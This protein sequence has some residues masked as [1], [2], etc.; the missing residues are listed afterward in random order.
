MVSL[1]SANKRYVFDPYNDREMFCGYFLCADMETICRYENQK[2]PQQQ[3]IKFTND[4]RESHMY[5]VYI[6]YSIVFIVFIYAFDCNA[7]VVLC[8]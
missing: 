8:G 1:R 5:I 4:M 7:I 6:L 2:R 3:H